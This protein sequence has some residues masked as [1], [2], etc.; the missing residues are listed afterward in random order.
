[1][2]VNC[3]TYMYGDM[4]EA[5]GLNEEKAVLSSGL[6]TS[7]IDREPFFFFPFELSFLFLV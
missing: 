5:A 4:E 6:I 2:K 3:M 1:M 7:G